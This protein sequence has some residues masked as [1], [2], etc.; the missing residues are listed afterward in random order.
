MSQPEY[1]QLIDELVKQ[2]HPWTSIDYYE[3]ATSVRLTI[4]TVQRA[5]VFAELQANPN[6][7][8]SGNP[9]ISRALQR[10]LFDVSA[11]G[12]EVVLPACEQCNQQA[13]LIKTL[14]EEQRLCTQC[15]G[16]KARSRSTCIVCGKLKIV[17]RRTPQGPLCYTCSP[18]LRVCFDC[19]KTKRVAKLHTAGPLC[20]GC[21][22]R[23]RAVTQVCP[24]CQ[25]QRLV[26][27]S[28]P[29]GN[30]TCST[31]AGS[32]PI[33]SCIDCG[34]ETDM[35]GRRCATCERRW[36]LD[37][38]FA[39]SNGQTPTEMIPVKTILM[40]SANPART[41]RWAARSTTANI[42]KDIVNKST[43]TTY[44]GLS[45]YPHSQAQPIRALLEE[46]GVLDPAM[47]PTTDFEQWLEIHLKDV[48]S[49]MNDLIRR[50]ALWGVL[51]RVKISGTHSDHSN[52]QAQMIR[53]RLR[54]RIVTRFLKFLGE[55]ST[56]IH[57]A[58][59]SL[60]D[61]F[62]TTFPKTHVDLTNFIRWMRDSRLPTRIKVSKLKSEHSVTMLDQATYQS[63]IQQ[64][65]RTSEYPVRA[66]LIGFLVGLY[67]I[68]L[69]RI[70]TLKTDNI[71]IDEHDLKIRLASDA[72]VM[73][74]TMADLVTKQLEVANHQLQGT[75]TTWLFPSWNPG[76]HLHPRTL[77]HDMKKMG[78]NTVPF[79]GA[80][81]FNLIQTMPLS[82][83]H[84]LTGVGY[85]TLLRWSEITQRDWTKY[86]A[87]RLS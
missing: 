73:P 40:K 36:R 9:R 15:H 50:F 23:R 31:C 65:A 64:L 52:V 26:A 81:I 7:A 72:I 27:Y 75:S 54:V 78:I 61:R 4:G 58:D 21:H 55:N 5:R 11:Q 77:S 51:P 76:R 29:S 41:V 43:P 48:P 47:A 46:A 74:R 71:I 45:K 35:Y 83:V 10:L 42:L 22:A 59:H 8:T 17:N 53:A 18:R 68:K 6:L 32:V 30:I 39:D 44:E 14:P 62:T 20:D 19:G 12:C 49:P 87:L 56:D 24:Q 28:A 86:P 84:D 57:H 25:N 80:A 33:Y 67:G 3:L 66:R 70:A 85:N 34:T 37:H 69:T 1:R 82:I 16:R 13:L 79:R 60:F 38:L 63:T 2:G